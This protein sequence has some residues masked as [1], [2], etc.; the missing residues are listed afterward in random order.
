MAAKLIVLALSAI[1]E[2]D[3]AT[4]IA[5]AGNYNPKLSGQRAQYATICGAKAFRAPHNI[6]A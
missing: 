4:P 3:C 6:T 5:S 1:A 2:R